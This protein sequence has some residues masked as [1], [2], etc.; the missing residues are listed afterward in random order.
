MHCHVD[1]LHSTILLFL[2]T[3]THQALPLPLGGTPRAPVLLDLLVVAL[4]GLCL[5]D[6][7]P[8]LLVAALSCK[9]EDPASLQACMSPMLVSCAKQAQECVAMALSSPD[10]CSNHHCQSSVGPPS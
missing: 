10:G 3:A 5:L 4:L 7:V 9:L 6:G 2:S 8:R 1:M